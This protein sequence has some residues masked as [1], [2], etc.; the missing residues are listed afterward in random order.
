VAQ[1]TGIWTF[2]SSKSLRYVAIGDIVDLVSA[3]AKKNSVHDTGH[4]TR[5]APAAFRVD[6]MMG[7]GGERGALLKL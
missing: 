2:L 5:N 1:Q 4:V 6:R 7:M 3:R